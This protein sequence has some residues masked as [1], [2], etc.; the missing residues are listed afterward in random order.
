[1]GAPGQAADGRSPAAAGIRRARPSPASNDAGARTMGYVFGAVPSRRLPQE[2][3]ARCCVQSDRDPVE[4]NDMT[5]RGWHLPGSGILAAL[6]IF[7]LAS[8]AR[9]DGCFVWNR[10]ADLYEPS[11]KAIIHWHRGTETMVLQVKYEGPAEDF[12]CPPG[13]RSPRSSPRRARSPR[14][15]CTPRPAGA[16]AIAARTASRRT[17][18]RSWSEKWWE[19]MTWP[20]SPPR[21]PRHSATG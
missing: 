11:Q 12:A 3:C 4:A 7:G 13:R 16:G 17:R 14:S 10:G 1:M 18:S 8:G 19:C 21:T 15:A 2:L 6:C 9:A 20:C 5:T